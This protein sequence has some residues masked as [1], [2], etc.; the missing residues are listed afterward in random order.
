[1][2][3]SSRGDT[4]E[5]PQQTPPPAPAPPAPPA[6]APPLPPPLE[7]GTGSPRVPGHSTVAAGPRAEVCPWE[8]L[9]AP[10]GALALQ[11]AMAA[12]G[13]SPKKV[14]G[15]GGSQPGPCSAREGRGT[16]GLPMR[17]RSTEVAWA[18]GGLRTEI[19]PWEGSGDEAGPPRGG[20]GS[21]GPGAELGEK[22]PELPAAA[23][24]TA[25]RAGGRTAEVCPWE[26]AEGGPAPRAEICPWEGPQ[27]TD[28]GSSRRV[29]VCPWEGTEE[30][31]EGLTAESP[32]LPKSSST[33][34]GNVGSKKA[35]VCPWEAEEEPLAKAEIC[36][37]EVS[38]APPGKGRGS[39]DPRG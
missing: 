2:P 26:S 32:A 6:P 39:Q 9:G 21:V 30:P 19:C 22:P 28:Q 12:G 7:L 33:Q 3:S 27:A 10:P 35:D 38:P 13:G 4:S 24:G 16:E 15:K 20:P 23:P 36:P 17:S 8:A 29:S 1:S 5:H 37:W 31:G 14:L 25:G 34:A 11:K 18:G